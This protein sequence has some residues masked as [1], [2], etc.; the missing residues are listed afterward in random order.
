VEPYAAEAPALLQSHPADAHSSAFL[1]CPFSWWVAVVID[2][3]SRCVKGF[4]LFTKMLES[5]DI[6]EF[7]DRLTERTGSK[8]RHVM[9]EKG[10]QFFCKEYKAWCRDRLSRQSRRINPT[11]PPMKQPK[12]G[13]IPISASAQ[14]PWTNTRN[15]KKKNYRSGISRKSGDFSRS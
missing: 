2:Q 8:P 9:T 3:F 5:I 7:L 1:R 14:S 13:D 12:I 10:G 11:V 6:C 15:G 4:A